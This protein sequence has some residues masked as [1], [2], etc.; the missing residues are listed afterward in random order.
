[1]TK[2]C[3]ARVDNASNVSNTIVESVIRGDT[4][5]L[6]PSSFPNFNVSAMTKASMGP[7][8]SPATSP[9]IIPENKDSKA[10]TMQTSV[11]GFTYQFSCMWGRVKFNP[12]IKLVTCI[13]AVRQKIL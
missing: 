2:S 4:A 7:G 5:T 10:F 6:N 9:R 13:R 11:G 3:S 12:R 1:M 8:E